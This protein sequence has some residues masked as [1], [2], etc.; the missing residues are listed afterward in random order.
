MYESNVDLVKA[1]QDIASDLKDL[2][3]MN[4]TSATTLSDDIRQNQYCPLVRVEKKK[5]AVREAPG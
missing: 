3:I 5:I 4:T 1:T 2:V